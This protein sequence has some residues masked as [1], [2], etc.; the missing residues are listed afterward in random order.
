MKLNK[1]IA[2]AAAVLALAACNKQEDPE[3]LTSAPS[4]TFESAGGMQTFGINSNVDWTITV[5]DGDGWVTV[6]PMSGEGNETVTVTTSAYEEAAGRSARLTISGGDLVQTVA[7]IQT[8]PAVP[9]DP[10]VL[11]YKVQARE[12]DLTVEVPAGFAYK[13]TIPSEAT[14]VTVKE[15]TK[16]NV[17]LHFAANTTDENRSADILIQTSDDLTLE[18]IKTVQSWRNVEPGELL[19]EE[20]FFTGALIESTN[21]SDT[22]EGDQYF[23]LTNNADHTVYA[24]GVLLVL[25]FHNS[26]AATTGANYTYPELTDEIPVGTVYAIPGKGTDVPVEPGQSIVIAMAAENFAKDNP[27]GV[28]LSGA[29][30]ELYDE[31]DFFPD[32]DNPDVANMNCWFK[33]SFTITGLHNRGMESYAIAIAPNSVTAESFMENYKWEGKRVMDWNGF[34]FENDIRDGYKIPNAWVLDGINCGVAEQL[35]RLAFNAS[36]D[37][38]WTGV[39]E[40]QDDATRYGK[41]VIRKAKDGKLADTNNSTNDFEVRTTPSLKK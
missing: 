19:I 4:L 26:N 11:E 36:V 31:N 16:E 39:S 17:T 35:I 34:H 12:Q 38:G 15:T 24:D 13:V 22:S 29:D 3:L 41:T 28:D 40:T 32:T 1:L 2:V 6:N 7:V 21:T 30:F 27:N 33:S 14:Y 10:S 8:R 37:A 9:A 20:V 18:T 5:A 23:K 25:G